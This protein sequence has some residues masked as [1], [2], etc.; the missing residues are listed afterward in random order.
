MFFLIFSAVLFCCIKRWSRR[1]RE[2]ASYGH[3]IL[4]SEVRQYRP[5]DIVASRERELPPP[6]RLDTAHPN[7][8]D[9][10]HSPLPSAIS[11]V[12]PLLSHDS[13]SSSHSISAWNRNSALS[14]GTDIPQIAMQQM[15]TLPN[16]HDPFSAPARS[17][18][19]PSTMVSMASS[20][21][22]SSPSDASALGSAAMT[23]AF[24]SPGGDDSSASQPQRQ[25]SALHT[26]LA[27]YQKELELDHTKRG[28][29]TRE[30]LQ[31]PPPEYSS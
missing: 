28:L 21:P 8:Y 14:Q 13:R 10:S 6:P 20:S 9:I 17:A 24:T 7:S 26:D 2:N 29:E 23:N 18:S 25:L 27:R 22:N 30:E 11:S 1:A 15:S 12:A 16:P 4:S 3:A 31:D 5:P 19:F